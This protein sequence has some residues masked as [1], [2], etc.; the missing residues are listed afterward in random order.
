MFTV[1][2]TGG[3]GSGKSIVCNVFRNLNIPVYQADTEARRLMGES[4]FIRSGLLEYFGAAV[5]RKEELNREFLAGKIFSDTDARNYVN[6]LVHPAVREDFA[7][8]V[9]SQ[10]GVPYVLEEAALLLESGAWEELDYIVLVEAG[11][12]T[13]ITR[14]IKRDGLSRADVLARMGSQMEPEKRREYAD[15]IIRNDENEMV[16]PQVLKLDKIIRELAGKKP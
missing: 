16:I 12:E 5:F 15:F 14:I 4:P 1:G 13:R 6:S 3:I 9:R 2:V 10:A 8:W 11:V 7:R